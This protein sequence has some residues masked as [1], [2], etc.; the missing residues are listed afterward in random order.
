MYSKYQKC[1]LEKWDR[2]REQHN[3][4]L[5]KKNEL[6]DTMR[7]KLNR[8]EFA[9]KEAMLFLAKPMEG[10]TAWLQNDPSKSVNHK[11]RNP[12]EAKSVNQPQDPAQL[13][14]KQQKLEVI[15][16]VDSAA[17]SSTLNDV[18]A[19]KKEIE[20]QDIPALECIRLSLNYLRAAQNTVQALKIYKPPPQPGD[21]EDIKSPFDPKEHEPLSQLDDAA[22][23]ER[24]E[25]E[26]LNNFGK[27]LKPM[28]PSATDKLLQEIANRHKA[29]LEKTNEKASETEFEGDLTL[30]PQDD[31]FNKASPTPRKN[32]DEKKC[33]NCHELMLRIDHL[34]D[35]TTYLKRD[36][37]S[38]VAQ[39]NEERSCRQRIQLS[40]D[41]LDQELEELTSQL[42][43]QANKMVIDEATLREQIEN[44]N[45]ELAGELK[46]LSKKFENRE[47]ELKGLRRYLVALDSAKN[48]STSV[49]ISPR[50]STVSMTSP[51]RGPQNL[52][53]FH[54]NP[55]SFFSSRIG[56]NN[57]VFPF[58]PVD[59]ILLSEFA[60]HIKTINSLSNLAAPAQQA[61]FM[62]TLFMKRSLLEDIEPCLYYTYSNHTNNIKAASM[63]SSYKRRLFEGVLKSS[64][65]IKLYW[66][67][68]ETLYLGYAGNDTPSTTSL[69]PL[70]V[71][72][73]EVCA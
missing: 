68:K 20:A 73:D 14:Q 27:D 39:L 50:E 29:D 8:Y 4:V 47:E 64:V 21:T 18:P 54:S 16:D 6:I 70:K 3:H 61:A 28:D 41:I 56:P 52:N 5:S 65:D 35:Q 24:V 46:D 33:D 42:F 12:S 60:D 38:L 40:K 9:I 23:H 53:Y 69:T 45:H 43:D 19:V 59:G 58:I 57:S 10:Y 72:G 62:Q 55:A 2:E 31:E 30:A 66:S 22:K 13:A 49:V 25:S 15:T 48:R 11:D 71:T 63:S 51:V 1:S 44:N 17:P 67:S 37:V 32:L 7:V 34:S 26:Y 36:V